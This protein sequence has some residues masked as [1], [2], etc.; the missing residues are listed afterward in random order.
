MPETLRWLITVEAIGILTLPI[1]WIALPYLRDR[2][3]GLAKPFGLILV[4]G[5]VWLLSDIGLLPNSGGAY[6]LVAAAFGG[7]S[8]WILS[9]R[10]HR[11]TRFVRAEWP[12]L[13]VGELL[14]LVFF[15]AWAFIRSHNPEISGTEKPMELLMLNAV[16]ISEGAPPMD[17]WLAGEP[18]AYYYFGYW[19][20]GGI[21]QM[22]GVATFVGF[23]LSLALIAGMAASAAFSV[24][25]GLIL[26][27]R[28]RDR[29]ALPVAAFAAVLLLVASNYAGLWEFGAAKSLG[30]EGFYDWLAIK[31]VAVEGVDGGATAN[32][33]R[34]D[35]YWWWW[36]S[37]RVINSR[38]CKGVYRQSLAPVW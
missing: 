11:F 19:I 35:N 32:N 10:R 38:C 25:Y 24:A 15:A 31:D 3:A 33:W 5:L 6:W 13:L 29:A 27:G 37:S 30:S 8:A 26:P 20:L 21:G 2:G 36:H 34:P 7:I 14:F 12:A 16:T 23:N 28:I 4:G 18:V 1:A 9:D 22:S 17:P